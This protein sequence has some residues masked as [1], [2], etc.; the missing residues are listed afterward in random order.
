MSNGEMTQPDLWLVYIRRSY[1][2]AESGD[3]SDE[4]QEAA[5]RARAARWPYRDH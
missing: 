2:S 4:Q 1:K 3:V 5:A